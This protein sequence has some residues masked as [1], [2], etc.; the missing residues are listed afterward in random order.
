MEHRQRVPVD[1]RWL[2]MDRRG[3]P[4]AGIAIAL[5]VLLHWVI[6]AVNDAVAWDDPTRAGDVLDLGDGIVATP[7]VGWQLEEGFRTTDGPTV[8]VVADGA[9]VLLANEVATIRIVGATWDGTADAL[10]DQSNR[11]RETSEEADDRTFEVTGRRG[12]FTTT[13]GVTGVSE[14]TVA[15]AG[16]GRTFALVVDDRSGKAIGLV[17]TATAHDGS[18]ATVDPQVEQLVSSITTTE[19]PS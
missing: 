8:S 4:Y 12:S 18:L 9:T 17:V 2:G 15:P 1:Q 16:D 5:V 10:L 14:A 13:A 3:V 11:V 7:P 19:G 6:P